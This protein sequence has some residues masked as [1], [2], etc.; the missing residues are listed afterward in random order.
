MTVKFATLDPRSEV[1]MQARLSL[2]NELKLNLKN[3]SLFLRPVV[4]VTMLFVG[5]S[6]IVP[7][8]HITVGS[9]KPSALQ[10]SSRVQPS[11]PSTTGRS[12]VATGG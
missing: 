4:T 6:F 9:G 5:T 8:Y 11:P 7:W 2:D 12:A 1:A 3:V 10:T